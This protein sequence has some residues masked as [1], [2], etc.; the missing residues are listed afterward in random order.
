MTEFHNP[1]PGVPS[2]ESPFSAHIFAGA[3]AETQ[4]VARD[5]ERDGFAVIDFP[6]PEI[7]RIADAIKASLNSR[8]DWDFWFKTGH[9]VG[10][11]LRLQD[12]WQFDDNV[13]RIACNEKIIAL[14]SRLYGRRAWPFQTLN[15]PVGTQQ[16]YH[17]DSVHFSSIPERFMCGVWTALEDIDEDR[18]PLV[19]YPGSHKWPIFTNEHIGFCASDAER[20]ISQ[21]TFEPMWEALIEQSGIK[22]YHFL[23]KKGQA[24]IW[25]ANL[26]HGGSRQRS[27]ALTRWSQVTHYYFEDCA[28][29]TP[30]LSD[31]IY[32]RI[33]F[34]ERID[35]TTGKLVPHKYL[36][37]AIPEEYILYTD[38]ES[39]AYRGKF[40]AAQYYAANPDVEKAG[41]PALQH[42]LDFGRHEGR[43]LRPPD[44]AVSQP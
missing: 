23:P 4:R 37:L 12:A 14:L 19:Y 42:W 38:P 41:V 27:P 40:D 20:S 11:G 7:G 1:L 34:R 43:A 31:P 9:S 39:P 35:I 25:A 32:G 18:G 29:Y 8:Y 24:L 2:V 30:M 36:G 33:A 44:T 15:F 5:L 10:A 16:H 26:L 17:T 28:Y 22:P 3:D 13:K 21:T 6:D